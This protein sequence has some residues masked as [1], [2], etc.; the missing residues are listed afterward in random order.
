MF[1]LKQEKIGKDMFDNQSAVEH[2]SL[3]HQDDSSDDEILP[4]SRKPRS[5][6]F[7]DESE[8]P[9]QFPEQNHSEDK[10]QKSK[11]KEFYLSDEDEKF[12]STPTEVY[13]SDCVI[14]SL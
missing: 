12:D 8:T 5:E 11:F 13:L 9:P 10:N 6:I 1:S 14:M 2:P 7:D 3:D 4:R